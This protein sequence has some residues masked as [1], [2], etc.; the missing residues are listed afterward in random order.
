MQMPDR[1]PINIYK[2]S[3]HPKNLKA[4]RKVRSK[5]RQNQATTYIRAGLGSIALLAWLYLAPNISPARV[6]SGLVL[7]G[8]AP[9]L[10]FGLQVFGVHVAFANIGRRAVWC[11]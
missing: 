7:P 8:L 5:P 4:E 11:L 6:G 9:D 1:L 10:P 2:G 3:M